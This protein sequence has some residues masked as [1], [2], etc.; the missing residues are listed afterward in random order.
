MVTYTNILIPET[1]FCIGFH[2]AELQIIA[3]TIMPYSFFL[4]CGQ[5]CLTW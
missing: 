3:F 5:I 1:A 4:H 2:D